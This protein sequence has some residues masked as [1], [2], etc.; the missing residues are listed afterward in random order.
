MDE[1][2]PVSKDVSK[3]T[4][5]DDKF[6]A[7]KSKIDE[8]YR[9]SLEEDQGIS[10][11]LPVYRIQ[12]KKSSQPIMIAIVCSGLL[13]LLAFFAGVS[14]DAGG[15]DPGSGFYAGLVFIIIAIISSVFIAYIVK[16]KG[17][18]ALKY[19]MGFAFF[20]LTFLI[21]Y[22]FG[23]VPIFLLSPS[24]EVYYII[25]ITF[26]ITCGIT[27]LL[28]TTR[29][30]SGKMSYK[31]RNAYVLY[32]G[33]IVGSFMSI[34]FYE[35]SWLVLTMLIGISIWDI[36]S[37]KKGPIKKIMEATGTI[38]PEFEKK[39]A[40][41]EIELSNLEDSDL[42]IGIGDLAFYSLLASHTLV[43]SLFITDSWI[44]S[45]CATVASIVGIIV[46][47][48]LTIRALERNKIL[49][50]LPLSIFIGLGLVGIVTVLYLLIV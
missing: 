30:F 1:K 5:I 8:D 2:D 18:D 4:E 17:E 31:H 13:A 11:Y 6:T 37:V 32:I 15:D 10:K 19:V 41:G 24:I 46:G 20:L 38:D 39:V 14:G 43:A 27:G 42:E 9:E 33:I 12:F 7:L 22:F 25:S 44:F 28:V 49:P 21:T 23:D 35:N 34:I 48:K 40:N 29:F 26:L 36:I 45:L 3:K 47:S 50:G 16:K